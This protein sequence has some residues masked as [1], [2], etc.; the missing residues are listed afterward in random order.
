MNIPC[1]NPCVACPPSIGHGIGPID[2]ANP[3]VNLSSEEPDSDEFIGRRYV[4][5]PPPLGQTWYSIGCI[6]FCISDVSQE[7]A[8]LCALQQATECVS[9][10]WPQQCLTC[11]PTDD[12]PFPLEPRTLFRSN[13]QQCAFECPDGTFNHFTVVAGRFSNFSQAAADQ[14]AYSYACNQVLLNLICLSDLSPSRTC[15][16]APYSGSVVCS[17]SRTPIS[18]EVVGPIPD[19][20]LLVQNETTAFIQGT[21]TTPGDYTFTMNATD[22]AGNTTGKSLSL[23]IFGVQTMSLDNAEVGS[24]YAFMLVS[25]GT[26]A[27]TL[28]WSIFDGTLPDGLTLNSST[29]EISGTPTTEEIQSFTVSV[30]DGVLTCFRQLSITVEPLAQDCPDWNAEL[31]WGIASVTDQGLSVS[32]FIPNGVTSNNPSF[33]INCPAV[34]PSQSTLFNTGT[35]SYTGTGCNCNLHIDIVDPGVVGAGWISIDSDISGNLTFNQWAV[36][37]PGSF[38]IPFT[39]PDTGGNPSVIT[40]FM[41]GQKV[42]DTAPGT[43]QVACLITNI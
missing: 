22:P 35:L 4:Y 41:S 25:A 33:F 26:P 19:G 30:T 5:G 23:S 7:D 31:L 10:Q 28:V 21:P 43:M 3:F 8:N 20:L 34:N 36:L 2:P 32:L 18:F 17:S 13:A 24:P 29:G 11:P 27:G 14:E 40:V 12:N 37:G 1:V 9:T 15:A 39:I 38:D 6:G 42:W 16:S